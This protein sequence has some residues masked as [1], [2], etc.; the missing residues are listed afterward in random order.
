MEVMKIMKKFVVFLLVLMGLVI[1]AGCSKEEKKVTYV[2]NNQSGHVVSVTMKDIYQVLKPGDIVQIKT[3][4][5][6][7]TYSPSDKVSYT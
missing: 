1:T 4:E 3:A 5:S 2:L 6:T 7:F